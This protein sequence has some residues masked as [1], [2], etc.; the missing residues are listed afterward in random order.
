MIFKGKI[1][2]RMKDSVKFLVQEGRV[3]V[4]EIPKRCGISYASVHK[5]IY[6]IK[7]KGRQIKW[8]YDFLV[9]FYPLLSN[10]KMIID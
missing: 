9:F 4:K 6:L 10:K 3:T 8:S 5:R 2:P 1:D 7:Q